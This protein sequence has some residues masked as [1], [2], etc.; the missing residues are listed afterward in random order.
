M[1]KVITLICLLV[2][3]IEAHTKQLDP[4]SFGKIE[5]KSVELIKSNYFGAVIEVNFNATETAV[6]ISVCATITRLTEPCH[7]GD[8]AFDDTDNSRVLTIVRLR[9]ETSEVGFGVSTEVMLEFDLISKQGFRKMITE[10]YP[11]VI[12]WPDKNAAENV[13]FKSDVEALDFNGIDH[14]EIPLNFPGFEE[15]VSSL[16]SSGLPLKKIRASKSILSTPLNTIQFQE[17]VPPQIVKRALQ[18]V[19]KV[20]NTDITVVM[21]ETRPNSNS[22]PKILIG[23]LISKKDPKPGKIRSAKNQIVLLDD[24]LKEKALSQNADL[25]EFFS[26]L[27]FVESDSSYPVKQKIEQAYRLID[28][29]HGY[30]SAKSILEEVINHDANQPQAYLELARIAMKTNWPEGLIKAEELILTA[31]EIDKTYANTNVLLGYVYTNLERY[32]EAEAEYLL[33]EELGTDNLW[34]YA[35]WGLNEQKQ[36]HV[37]AAIDQYLKVANVELPQNRNIAPWRWV[38]RYSKFVDFMKDEKEY[39]ALDK[40]YGKYVKSP[41]RHNCARLNHAKIKLELLNDPEQAIETYLEQRSI[42]RDSGALLALAYYQVWL[43]SKS[44]GTKEDKTALR[45]ANALA[46][47]NVSLF[48]ELSQMPRLKKLMSMLSAEKDI[49][50]ISAKGQTALIMAIEQDQISATKILLENGANPNI[51]EE[52]YFPPLMRAIQKGNLKIVKLLVDAGADLEVLRIYGITP[53]ALKKE[54]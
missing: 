53:E 39:E 41:G 22:N 46:P 4:S 48:Y 21:N 5:V 1:L 38:F 52:D 7:P 42:C 45:R 37:K 40:L 25:E 2:C 54:I 35:N 9:S 3:S 23:R 30:S 18:S 31:K 27:G 16:V 24:A 32:E 47:S 6:P 43:M 51:P 12:D 14:I 13:F 15:I 19:S 8:E 49:N 26:H 50:E 11:L 28:S 10:A 33:A 17:E 29:G 34:L 36:G 20:V 44:N